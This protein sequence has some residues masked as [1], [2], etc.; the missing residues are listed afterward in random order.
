MGNVFSRDAL[1]AIGDGQNCTTV[2]AAGAD[3][4]LAV[5]SVV[6]DGIGEKVGDE[7]AEAVGVAESLC[8]AEVAV[9]FD[10]ALFGKWADASDTDA[11]VVRQIDSAAADGFLVGIE[12]CELEQRFG[13]PPHLLGGVHAFRKIS[14]RD[15]ACRGADVFDGTNGSAGEPPTTAEGEGQNDA[16]GGK[17]PPF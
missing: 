12:A 11:R 5:R 4:N 14:R 17:Q 15:P 1:S 8:G 9:D 13:E 2:F 6:V 16:T 3:E 7:L 10:A